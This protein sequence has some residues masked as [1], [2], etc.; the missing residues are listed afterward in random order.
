LIEWAEPGDSGR[1]A[2]KWPARI[3]EA[4]CVESAVTTIGCPLRNTLRR[5]A[6]ER[7]CAAL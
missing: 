3:H 4:R 2:S 1:P 7:W 6:S 5:I